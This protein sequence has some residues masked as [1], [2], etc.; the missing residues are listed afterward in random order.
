[1]DVLVTD[2]SLGSDSTLSYV[3]ELLATQ[4]SCALLLISGFSPSLE[5]IAQ[6]TDAGGVF[7]AKP[8]TGSAL[9][10]ALLV[11]CEGRVKR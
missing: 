7:L 8:F 3:D 9:R 11:A 5:R 1:M 2:V 4:A 10:G 6:L